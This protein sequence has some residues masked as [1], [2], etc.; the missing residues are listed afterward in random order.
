[1]AVFA[2]PIIPSSPK[3]IILNS[4]YNKFSTISQHWL[5]LYNTIIFGHRNACSE[6]NS[7]SIL[8][9]C[10]IG[11]FTEYGRN[12]LND[13][14]SPIYDNSHFKVFRTL[15]NATKNSTL[16]NTWSCREQILT[17][18]PFALH[19]SPEKGRKTHWSII[20]QTLP[21]ET[22]IFWQT[23]NFDLDGSAHAGSSRQVWVCKTRK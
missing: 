9:K 4:I 1:M 14:V 21:T 5:F 2:K 17:R 23:N 20:Q 13:W 8:L 18:R 10:P 6:K 19:Y 3:N 22:N 11:M 16:V 15:H 12:I 7:R